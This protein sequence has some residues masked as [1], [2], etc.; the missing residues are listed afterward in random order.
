VPQDHGL[1]DPDRP[2]A[3]ILV[4][5]QVRAADAARADAH[6]H[7]AGAQRRQVRVADPQVARTMDDRGLHHSTAS[8]P[9]ST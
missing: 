6:L 3:A 9:P 7:I 1:P 2:E 4:V 8:M 5:M